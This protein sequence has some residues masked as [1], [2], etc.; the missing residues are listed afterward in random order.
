[1]TNL[2]KKLIGAWINQPR[3]IGGQQLS[4][5]NNFGRAIAAI[6]PNK[7]IGKSGLTIQGVDPLSLYRDSI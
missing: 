4:S 7:R 2:P 1:M 3:K 6:V 5:N